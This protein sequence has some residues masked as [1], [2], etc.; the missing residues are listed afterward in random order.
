MEHVGE[1]RAK[2]FPREIWFMLS[3]MEATASK[4]PGRL[5][6]PRGILPGK[7]HHVARAVE[8]DHRQPTAAHRRGELAGSASRQYLSYN[9]PRPS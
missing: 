9:Q 8:P 6:G 4:R 5:T 2:V 1:D 3:P 7:A